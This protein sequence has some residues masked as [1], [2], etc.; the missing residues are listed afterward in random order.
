MFQQGDAPLHYALL[1]RQ[2]LFETF[3]DREI[4]GL[5]RMNGSQ[6]QSSY[7]HFI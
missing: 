1:V 5:M 2:F 7:L 4:E 3:P 6:D